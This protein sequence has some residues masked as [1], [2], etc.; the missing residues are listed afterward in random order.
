M[1]FCK[2]LILPAAA[3]ALSLAGPQADAAIIV[4]DSVD[5]LTYTS[6]GGATAS[7]SGSTLTIGTSKNSFVLGALPNTVEIDGDTETLTASFTIQFDN[8]PVSNGTSFGVGFAD[9][10]KAAASIPSIYFYEVAFD[11]QGGSSAV[12]FSEGDD[13]NLGKVDGNALT[14][15]PQTVSFSLTTSG[16]D[17][18][19]SS[20]SSLITST[21]ASVNNDVTPVQTTSFDTFYLIFNGNGFNEE[22]DGENVEATVTNLS[23]TTTGT[24]PEPGSLMVTAA[25]GLC[26]LTRRWRSV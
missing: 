23:I 11:P 19:L 16:A 7:V 12:T 4:A 24:I 25:A 10:T 17:M 26:L 20:T 3:A 14:T 21:T 6:S 15:S 22:F 9:S 2:Y 18:N 5:D 1:K 13:T 8:V